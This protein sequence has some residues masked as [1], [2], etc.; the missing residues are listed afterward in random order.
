MAQAAGVPSA[1][2]FP[3]APT[4]RP[5]RFALGE[6]SVPLLALPAAAFLVALFI[7]PFLYGLDL[8]LR[9]EGGLSLANYL[10]FFHDPRQIDA[11]LITF[12][13]ALPV[14][15]LNVVL[16]VPL[17][18]YMRR[19]VVGERVVNT[20]LVL[21]VTLGTVLIAEGMLS[22]FGPRG[23][24]SQAVTHLPG[25][26][27]APRLTHNMLGVQLSLLLQGL[28]FSFLLLLGHAS[29]IDPGLERAAAML[30]ATRWQTF[31][32]VTL[33]LMAPGIAIAFSLSFVANFSVFPSAVLVGQPSGPTRVL[34]IAAFQAAFEQFNWSMGSTIAIIMAL[35]ELLVIVLVL[36]WRERLYKG[37]ASGAAK[38]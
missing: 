13:I 9:P 5:G 3:T 29:G 23:W 22:Y 30:G 1:R 36:A 32:R 7:Y 10:A 4:T 34:A 35:I 33:P 28:P 38:G 19:G 20:L 31:R 16:A 24:F 11:I 17:A 14:S 12:Q 21:P 2:P 8:S 15:I 37:A 25:V 6:W 18:L 27:D 26:G